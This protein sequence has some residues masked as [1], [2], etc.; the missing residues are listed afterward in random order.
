SSPTRRS[1]PPPPTTATAVR[2]PPCFSA[3]DRPASS[4]LTGVLPGGAAQAS[5]RRAVLLGPTSNVRV[6]STPPSSHGDSS[7]STPATVYESTTRLPCRYRPRYRPHAR[8]KGAV[9]A[10]LLCHFPEGSAQPGPLPVAKATLPAGVGVLSRPK[11]R[12]LWCRNP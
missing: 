7:T 9:P 4:V 8:G 3:R 1:S 12:S 5:K 10:W 2:A 11:R 6:N